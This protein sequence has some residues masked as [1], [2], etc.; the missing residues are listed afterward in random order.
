MNYLAKLIGVSS[1]SA[2]K[3]TF[4]IENLFP[5][6]KEVHDDGHPVSYQLHFEDI[7][8]V[9]DLKTI[10]DEFTNLST[11]VSTTDDQEDLL[12]LMDNV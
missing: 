12:S 6:S 5:E 11:N 7:S 9:A 3:G 10:M 2:T 4:K 8:P 1:S